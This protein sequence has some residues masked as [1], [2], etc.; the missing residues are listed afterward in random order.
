MPSQW[1]TPLQSNTVPQRL[2]SCSSRLLIFLSR[3]ANIQAGCPEDKLL[4]VRDLYPNLISSRSPTRIQ[5]ISPVGSCDHDT[6]TWVSV[7]KTLLWEKSKIIINAN[8]DHFFYLISWSKIWNPVPT[9]GI[10]TQLVL[11]VQKIF[12]IQQR[13]VPPA[14]L[15]QSGLTVCNTSIIY[16]VSYKYK[17]IYNCL[18]SP[19]PVYESDINYSVSSIQFLIG[20]VKHDLVYVSMSWYYPHLCYTH[21]AWLFLTNERK[22]DD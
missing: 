9:M 3:V 20:L 7:P 10:Q 2:I 8:L 11:Y 19:Y 18:L 17:W 14:K 21:P 16:T 4:A 1:E 13:N 6:V 12:L 15:L 5:L 22:F